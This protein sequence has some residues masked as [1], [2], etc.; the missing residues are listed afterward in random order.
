[1]SQDGI[2]DSMDTEFEQTL[3]ESEGQGSLGCMSSWGITKSD[4]T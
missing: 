1:M 3:G 2:S 4:L